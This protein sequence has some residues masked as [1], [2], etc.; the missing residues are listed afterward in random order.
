MEG[1]LGGDVLDICPLSDI[2]PS[3]LE[4]QYVVATVVSR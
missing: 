3:F 1:Y 2:S 4:L